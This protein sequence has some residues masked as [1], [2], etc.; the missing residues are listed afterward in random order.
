[1]Y[2]LRYLSIVMLV[3]VGLS[4]LA[5]L[6]RVPLLR[7]AANLWIVSQE[8]TRADAVVVLGG[9]LEE[10]PFVAADMYQKGLAKTVLVSQVAESRAVKVGIVQGHTEANYQALLKLGVPAAAIETFGI[11]NKSTYDEAVELRAWAYTHKVTTIIIPTEIFSSRRVHW[12]LNRVFS[13]LPIHIEVVAFDQPNVTRDDWWRED[14]GLIAFQNE[15][16]KYIYY[17]LHH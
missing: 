3:I 1:M 14:R 7:G 15:I 5:W 2:R 17:R 4:G 8:P 10:R 11:S 9:G 13:G 6:E 12:I 16:L